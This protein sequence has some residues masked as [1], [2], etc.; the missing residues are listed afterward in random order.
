M[1]VV[2]S[3]ILVGYFVNFVFRLFRLVVF[4]NLKVLIKKH[5]KV[6]VTY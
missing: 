1:L 2:F 5:M 4:H 3:I 6:K